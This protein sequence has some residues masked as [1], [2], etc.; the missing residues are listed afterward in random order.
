[1]QLQLHIS[2]IMVHIKDNNRQGKPVKT[3]GWHWHFECRMRSRL[4]REVTYLL[5][6]VPNTEKGYPDITDITEASGDIAKGCS[7]GEQ[8][9]ARGCS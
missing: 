1:M 6:P 2:M 7:W 8:G 4:P 9:D 3:K 5:P